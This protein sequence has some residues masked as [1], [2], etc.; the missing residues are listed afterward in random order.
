MIPDGD[1]ISPGAQHAMCFTTEAPEVACVMHRLSCE[2]KIETRVREP[3][4]LAKFL[5]YLYRKVAKGGK[6]PY[7]PATHV[8]AGV[9]LD[10]NNAPPLHCQRVASDAP[11]GA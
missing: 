3:N 10:R 9:R 7:G 11:A 2:H 6:A 4:V 1:E 8:V 5:A